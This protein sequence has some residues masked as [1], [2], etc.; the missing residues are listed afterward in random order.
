M[1][2]G[3]DREETIRLTAEVLGCDPVEAAEIWEME[4]GSYA[5]DVHDTTDYDALR[6]QAQDGTATVPTAD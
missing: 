6:K 3:K 1:I 5:G 4:H 2:E